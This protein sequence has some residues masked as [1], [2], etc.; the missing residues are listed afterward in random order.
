MHKTLANTAAMGCA[1]TMAYLAYG[2]NFSDDA[3]AGIIGFIAAMALLGLT[4]AAGRL[5]AQP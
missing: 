5:S 1:C 2:W 3:L 4:F